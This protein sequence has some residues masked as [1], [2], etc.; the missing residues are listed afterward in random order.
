MHDRVAAGAELGGA[1][2]LASPD[3][4]SRTYLGICVNSSNDPL[5]TG[6]FCIDSGLCTCIVLH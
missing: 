3:L 5:R 1:G 4:A 6:A 2:T